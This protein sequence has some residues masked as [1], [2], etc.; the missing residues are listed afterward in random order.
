VERPL[1]LVDA[2]LG[3]FA[4]VLPIAVIPEDPTLRRFDQEG[5]SLWKLPQDGPP[6]VAARQIAP[7][8][9]FGMGPALTAPGGR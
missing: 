7:A 4:A 2:L 8:L 6:R 3:P 9:G 1:L 5:R